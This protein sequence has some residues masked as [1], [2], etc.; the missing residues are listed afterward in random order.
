MT[1]DELKEILNY[2]PITGI[3][4]WKKGGKGIKK[5]VVIFP[6]NYYGE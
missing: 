4:T 2:D 6:L 5:G 1:Q 3:F